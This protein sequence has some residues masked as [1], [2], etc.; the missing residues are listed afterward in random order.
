MQRSD[1]SENSL[2][3]KWLITGGRGFVG[4]NLRI[5]LRENFS[6]DKVVVVDNFKFDTGWVDDFKEADYHGADVVNYKAMRDIF[7][8]T[9][10]DYVVHLAGNT[11]VR[12]SMERP[13]PCFSDNIDGTLNCL[14]LSREFKVKRVI[15]AS[16]CGVVGNQFG[17]INEMVEYD[18]L[19]P[20]AASKACGEILGM[21]YWGFGV[22]VTILRFSNIFGPW[23]AHKSSVIP[24][25]IKRFINKKSVIVY[26]DGQQTRNFL[27]VEDAIGAILKVVESKASGIFCIGSLKSHTVN[28]VIK[29]LEQAFGHSVKRDTREEVGGE[30][31][32]IEIDTK[33]A[34]LGLH[35]H[36]KY[37]FFDGVKKTCDWYREIKY[38]D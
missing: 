30:V 27:Y 29:I 4:T 28:E 8:E 34:R 11:E 36:C 1:K 18:P 14:D 20:Y 13:M 2:G 9:E 10:P 33:K 24:Q 12:K 32:N 25:F 26:G 3:K 22:P 15:I 21:S 5:A 38:A 31:H 16:S 23:S 7:V 19:S 37:S 17:S 6:G 35:F